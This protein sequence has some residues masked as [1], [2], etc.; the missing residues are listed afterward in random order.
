MPKVTKTDTCWIWDARKDERGY[1]WFSYLGQ[2]WYA[3]R[4]MAKVN[5]LDVNGKVVRHLCHNR[6]CVNPAH[7]AVGT[8]TENLQDSMRNGNARQAKLDPEKVRDIRT[9]K[10]TI[11]EYSSKYAVSRKAVY[12]VQSGASWGWVTN[13]EEK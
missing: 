12:M 10:L 11:D 13:Q 7:L 6:S 8:Q 3:H 2:P 5:G 4:F 9:K 1:G